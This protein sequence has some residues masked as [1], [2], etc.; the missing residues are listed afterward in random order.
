MSL[1][2]QWWID[3][4]GEAIIADGDI[5]IGNQ[6]HETIAFWAALGGQVEDELS[7]QDDQQR[8][9][10]TIQEYLQD[11]SDK[12]SDPEE[13]LAELEEIKPGRISKKQAIGLLALGAD[14]AAV[15]YF[16][17]AGVDA[18]DFMMRRYNWIRV[19]DNN[20]QLATLDDDALDRIREFISTEY[21][22]DEDPLEDTFEI[23]EIGSK[24][25]KHLSVTG[26]DLLQSGKSASALKYTSR[27]ERTGFYNPPKMTNT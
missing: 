17:D 26:E 21:P 23:E 24:K 10:E 25:S 27:R 12:K 13:I 15:E 8:T 3:D 5:T 6:D 7:D 9:L 11:Q 2:S 1:Q 16:R 14:E 19:D 20:F 22:E 18:R 4:S